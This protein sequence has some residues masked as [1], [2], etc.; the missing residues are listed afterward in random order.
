MKV[1]FTFCLNTSLETWHYIIKKKPPTTVYQILQYTTR[2]ISILFKD[3]PPLCLTHMVK[4][5][6]ANTQSGISINKHRWA[7]GR[8]SFTCWPTLTQCNS[9]VVLFLLS[10]A[11]FH[12]AESVHLSPHNTEQRQMLPKHFTSSTHWQEHDFWW[13]KALKWKYQP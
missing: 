7:W 2:F 8:F 5:T 1:C 13:R 6:Q 9:W 3:Q 12:T 11:V 4:P 10:D